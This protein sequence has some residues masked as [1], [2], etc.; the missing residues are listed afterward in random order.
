LQISALPGAAVERPPEA[1]GLQVPGSAP[2]ESGDEAEAVIYYGTMIG[3]DRTPARAPL[4]ARL[5]LRTGQDG[6]WLGPAWAVLCGALVAGA[7]SWQGV[8][9]LRL[10]L[11]VLLVEGGWGTLWN[12]A[13]GEDWLPV[14]GAWRAWQDGRPVRALPYTLPEAPGGRL[15]RGLGQLRD[16]WQR[17]LWP[18]HGAAFASLALGA[19]VSL[20]AAIPLGP[21]LVL[22][23]LAVVAIVQMTFLLSS[24]GGAASRGAEGLVHIG[25]PWFAGLLTF[26]RMSLLAVLVALCYAA[27]YAG[28]LH[29]TDARAEPTGGNR[30]TGGALLLV[31]GQAAVVVL[32]AATWR[33]LP[34][35]VTALLI[36]P[37]AILIAWH[38]PGPAG[39]RAARA[40]QWPLMVAMAVV[41]LAIM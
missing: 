19:V 9:A 29:F 40:A 41:A 14:F 12:A 39:V 1:G 2:G 28:L 35:L 6:L 18:E 21:R 26:G 13:C 3:T 34:A 27:A 25:L 23:S 4:H 8:D 20:L 5:L 24:G 32:L 7:F 31:L 16:W 36:F 10:A 33:Q 37:T 17:A 30:S 38:I 15:A 11:V 22:L